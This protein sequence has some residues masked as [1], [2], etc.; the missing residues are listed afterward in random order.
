MLAK[1]QFGA[2]EVIQ[3]NIMLETKKPI[4]AT[5][6]YVTL[7]G[8]NYEGAEIDDGEFELPETTVFFSQ[9]YGIGG[10]GNYQSGPIPFQIMVPQHIPNPKIESDERERWYLKAHLDKPGLDLRNKVEISVIH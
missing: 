5:A 10:P 6:L 8:T 1:N 9:K 4:D 7:Q 2:G 3:G